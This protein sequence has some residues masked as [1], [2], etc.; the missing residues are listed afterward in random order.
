MAIATDQNLRT[1]AHRP[2]HQLFNLLDSGDIDQRTNIILGCVAR[3]NLHPLHPINQL[4][5][6]FRVNRAMNK[7]AVCAHAGLPGIAEF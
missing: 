7:N 6:H 5:G 1:C 4:L 2:R 3:P